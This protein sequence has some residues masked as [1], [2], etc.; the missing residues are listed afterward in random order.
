MLPPA[1]PPSSMARRGEDVRAV[2]CEPDPQSSDA[3][4]TCSRGDAIHGYSR[5]SVPCESGVSPEALRRRAFR[6][7]LA[8]T[9]VYCLSYISVG[10][11][12]SILGPSLEVRRPAVRVVAL[13]QW[14]LDYFYFF[15]ARCWSRPSP[16]ERPR[17][18]ASHHVN[19]SLS[20]RLKNFS[21]DVR[22]GMRPDSR[23][24]GHPPGRR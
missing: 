15:P 3:I 5:A 20:N 21:C 22:E 9:A 1:A 12:V 23:A 11:V 24:S 17:S 10:V 2:D 8:I 19:V 16:P 18:H 7:R 4:A 13:E 14:A 6:P